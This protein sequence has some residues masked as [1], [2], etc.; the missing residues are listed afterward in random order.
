MDILIS[1]TFLVIHHWPFF[2]AIFLDRTNYRTLASPSVT[3]LM[4]DPANGL[5]YFQTPYTLELGEPN[6]GILLC[7]W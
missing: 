2:F 1:L 5:H 4:Q 7:I 6:A 3:T